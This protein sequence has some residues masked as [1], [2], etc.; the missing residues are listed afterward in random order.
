[1]KL[2]KITAV[3]ENGDTNKRALEVAECLRGSVAH[4]FIDKRRTMFRKLGFLIGVDVDY[5]V[6]SRNTSN[7]IEIPMDNLKVCPFM[8]MKHHV[9]V[10]A[11]KVD[12]GIP[13]EEIGEIES[14]N[15]YSKYYVEVNELWFNEVRL[16]ID[17]LKKIEGIEVI[18]S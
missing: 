12:Q 7:E 11:S 15:T 8:C 10:Q 2:I 3:N 13:S 9:K 14:L 18:E 1:M 4:G 17:E 5:F 16:D 6:C